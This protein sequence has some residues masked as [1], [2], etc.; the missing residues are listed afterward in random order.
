MYRRS[1]SPLLLDAAREPRNDSSADLDSEAIAVPSGGDLPS[2]AYVTSPRGARSPPHPG[3]LRGGERRVSPPATARA[4]HPRARGSGRSARRVLQ[5]TATDDA[6][7][8]SPDD[9]GPDQP[10]QPAEHGKA[11]GAAELRAQGATRR[12]G[13]LSRGAVDAYRHAKDAEV[14]KP[15]QPASATD[16]RQP[17]RQRSQKRQRDD[18]AKKRL[19]KPGQLLRRWR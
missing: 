6:R 17:I 7:H 13:G 19:K 12:N 16:G 5:T 11:Q 2:I 4:W 10:P 15:A 14:E 18:A 3:D 1:R 8:S 9:P